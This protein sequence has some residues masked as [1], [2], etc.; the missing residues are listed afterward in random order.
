MGFSKLWRL[1]AIVALALMVSLAQAAAPKASYNRGVELG[2]QGKFAEAQAAFEEALRG[3]DPQSSP[4]QGC[5]SVLADL[6]A[7]RIKDQ[8]AVHLFRAF[9]A[10]NR[11]QTGEAIRE[12]NR[13]VE[14]S[15][16]YALAYS[17]RADAYADKGQF[18]QALADYNQALK[19]NPQYATA[20][21]N[22]G[23]L[24]AKQSRPDQALA[25]FN[26]ALKINPRYVKAYY[27]RGNIHLQQGRYDQAIADFNRLTTLDPRYPHAYVRKGLAYEK[28][29]R[30]REA[31]ATYQAYLKKVDLKAQDP[32]QVRLVRDK[33]RELQKHL[34]Q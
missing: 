31:L 1:W 22:R 27:N 24:Q 14:L 29:G 16:H 4:V 34:P 33:I 9:G 23:I 20:Y 26:R 18:D 8:T 12:L 5:L 3:V 10:Y 11:F 15:P 17:Q 13:V 21:L 28:A 7:Q 32:R 6:K 2:A 30:P 25:D 19:I